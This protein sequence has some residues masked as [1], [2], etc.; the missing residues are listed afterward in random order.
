MKKK[1]NNYT[2]MQ[3]GEEN[4]ISLKLNDNPISKQLKY[5]IAPEYFLLNRKDEN[6]KYYMLNKTDCIE[7]KRLSLNIKHTKIILC[8]NIKNRANSLNYGN[9][10]SNIDR[11]GSNNISYLMKHNI[12]LKNYHK[13]K[14]EQ[15][16]THL[17]M[18]KNKNKDQ[19]ENELNKNN[20]IFST[21]LN[22]NKKFI[23]SD[24]KKNQIFFPKKKKDKKEKE[25]YKSNF[26]K[27]NI[28]NLLKRSSRKLLGSSEKINIL[29]FLFLKIKKKNYQIINKNDDLSINLKKDIS[30][31]SYSQNKENSIPLKN[32]EDKD[33]EK[34]GENS[35]L[36]SYNEH[37][38]RHSKNKIKIISNILINDNNTISCRENYKNTKEIIRSVSK[39]TEKD[40][41][42]KK[43]SSKIM[44]NYFSHKDNK[45]KE[46]YEYG[47]LYDEKDAEMNKIPFKSRTQK[48]HIKP[49]N[50]I[51][52]NKI[53]KNN[54]KNNIEQ[55]YAK[56]N[57]SNYNLDLLE[58]CILDINIKRDDFLNKNKRN[59]S[60]IIPI[61]ITKNYINSYNDNKGK[62]CEFVKKERRGKSD[63]SHLSS[64]NDHHDFVYHGNIVLKKIPKS[65]N[66]AKNVHLNEEYNTQSHKKYNRK[67]E[68]KLFKYKRNKAKINKQAKIYKTDEVHENINNNKTRTSFIDGENDKK[69]NYFNWLGEEK[70]DSISRR[71][72]NNYI[73]SSDYKRNG[74]EL[75]YCNKNGALDN[76]IKNKYESY[77]DSNFTYDKNQIRRQRKNL[78]QY[79]YE[80]NKNKRENQKGLNKSETQSDKVKKKNIYPI[81]LSINKDLEGSIRTKS[82]AT[83]DVNKKKKFEKNNMKIQNFITKDELFDICI[84][85]ENYL[86]NEE[87]YL[88]TKNE[89]KKS[90][91]DMTKSDHF[92]K[93]RNLNTPYKFLG[94]NNKDKSENN[95]KITEKGIKPDIRKDE[96]IIPEY[97]IL[98]NTREIKNEK[99]NG[100]M[101]NKSRY[102]KNAEIEKCTNNIDQKINNS[103]EYNKNIDSIIAH[104]SR[105]NSSDNMN[106]ET[107]KISI[108]EKDKHNGLKFSEKMPDLLNVLSNENKLITKIN[109][110]GI[111]SNSYNNAKDDK[112]SI[113]DDHA[114]YMNWEF[115]IN[116]LITSVSKEECDVID[117][118][119]HEKRNKNYFKTD[120]VTIMDKCNENAKN[121]NKRDR[122]KKLSFYFMK[123]RYFRY[124]FSEYKKKKNIV[125]PINEHRSSKV[126][127]KKKKKFKKI[128]LLNLYERKKILQTCANDSCM[129]T[130]KEHCNLGEF[131]LGKQK[132]K[133]KGRKTV[134][135]DLDETLIHSSLRNDKG[136][137]FRINI[138]LG[139]EKCF[140]Y[141]NK[142]PGVDYFFQEISKYYEIVIFTASMPKY[143]N[144]VIDKLDVNRVCSYRLFRE[145]CTLW[146]NNY[147][148]D[149]R[150]LG[151]D[152]KNVII[153]DNSTYVQKFCADNCFLIKSWFDDPT[154]TE[155]YKLIPFLKGISNKISIINE[156]KAYKKLKKKKRNVIK[157]I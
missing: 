69:W 109:R 122:R 150:L 123:F 49:E 137:S 25:H 107:K 8:E 120:S 117:D 59:L 55:N 146:N 148:K 77:S 58:Y 140:I 118:Y 94:I 23:Y 19:I 108:I 113:Y 89:E 132:G 125:I 112:N 145:S 18:M 97:Y 131:L 153:I 116:N 67:K 88:K 10:Y 133:Y 30:T 7:N 126:F 139:N 87:S 128:S 75:K 70:N 5:K 43:V 11:R 31:D 91:K 81:S 82:N 36:K 149:I 21:L 93:S 27:K 79:I 71:K 17:Q 147:V 57:N 4:N 138:E 32:K 86:K 12:P 14:G 121:T 78:F 53:K 28:V 101:K 20:G 135:L 95:I 60:E 6:D 156:L 15:N 143:A 76:I 90:D 84:K 65:T 74:K 144:A 61:K 134:V 22:K 72:S 114:S 124:L 29:K 34:K 39:I 83:K 119:K 99:P 24:K 38:K 46:Y 41:E 92:V 35:F 141:V 103:E 1:Q 45:R 151:R 142:R 9:G 85:E 66:G 56:N 52:I 63:N 115:N 51:S 104:L 37:N 136:S 64:K 127:R 3:K 129:N 110:N 26:A 111:N 62:S 44:K 54:S 102:E 13:N 154:D 96:I 130:H 73:D 105:N 98:S 48:M 157:N 152:L 47:M 50:V 33:A 42:S 16:C 100:N 40:Y 2:N 68:L 80:K 155:L 106:N